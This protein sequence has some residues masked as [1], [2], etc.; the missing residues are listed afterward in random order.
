M[1]IIVLVDMGPW[2]AV[3]DEWRDGVTI[4]TRGQPPSGLVAP[5]REFGYLWAADASIFNELGWTRWDESG[6]CAVIQP[7][8]QGVMIRRSDAP[9]SS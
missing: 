1:E 4:P 2:L 6:L 3:A 9:E 5:L 8:E 7:F